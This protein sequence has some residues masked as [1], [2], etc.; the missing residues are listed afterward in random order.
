MDINC[1]LAM[2]AVEFS[3]T[4]SPPPYVAWMACHYAPTGKALSNLPRQLPLE[5][6]LI[7]DDSTPPNGHDPHQITE[8]LTQLVRELPI[9][10]IILDLQRKNLEENQQLAD[11]L[12][13]QPPCPVC[14]SPYYAQDLDCPVFLPPPPLHTPL[15]THIDKWAGRE[16]WLE[17][18]PETQQITVTKEGSTVTPLTYTPLPEECFWDDTICCRYTIQV[19]ED[20]AV[21]TLTRDMDMLQKLLT[22][23]SKHGVSKA[24]GLYQELTSFL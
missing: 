18:A 14:V 10:G 12:T 20:H 24:V 11:L 4:Q 7:V 6:L 5:S 15:M 17:A 13:K 9:S 21:F 2:T 23:A 8:Q 19:W 22:Q 1:Y 3:A 16:I